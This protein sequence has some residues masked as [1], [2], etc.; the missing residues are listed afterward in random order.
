MVVITKALLVWY[1]ASHYMYKNLCTTITNN[2]H[3][4]KSFTLQHKNVSMYRIIIIM[5]R[6]IISNH[7]YKGTWC[8]LH[9][10]EITG[11]W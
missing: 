8:K 9:L 11:L 10:H 2:I 5:Y 4:V 1:L 6:I 7:V 3:F